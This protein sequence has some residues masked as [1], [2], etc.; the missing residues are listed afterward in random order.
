VGRYVIAPQNRV[1]L[2]ANN[3]KLS[4]VRPLQFSYAHPLHSEHSID[5]SLFVTD[6]VTLHSLSHKSVKTHVHGT[7][8]RFRFPNVS[9]T[10]KV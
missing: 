9:I 1:S 5:R 6:P 3:S 8:L 10:S 7:R 4:L 2:P